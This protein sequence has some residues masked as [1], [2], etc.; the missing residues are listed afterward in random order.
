[1]IDKIWKM[2]GKLTL[3]HILCALNINLTFFRSTARIINEFI[4]SRI[5]I[6]VSNNNIFNS[7]KPYMDG[8]NNIVF[9]P[10]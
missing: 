4:V 8:N 7:R 10:K 9:A 5:K 1:M 6:I 2:E 3:T